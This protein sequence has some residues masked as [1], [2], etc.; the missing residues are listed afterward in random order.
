MSGLFVVGS[1]AA[2]RPNDLMQKETVLPCDIIIKMNTHNQSSSNSGAGAFFKH[3]LK[4]AFSTLT[5]ASVATLTVTFWINASIIMLLIFMVGIFA[6][7]SDDA[8][9]GQSD[10][11][12]TTTYGS[13]EAKHKILSIP[14]TGPIEG[15]QSGD[16]YGGIFAD[17][18][19]SYGYDLKRELIR[20]ANSKEYAAVILEI[21]SPGGT[22]YGSKAIADG[23]A[24][25]KEKTKRPVYASIQGMAASGGYWSAVSADKIIADSG[26]G[27]GSIGVIYGPFTYFDKP[28]AIDGGILGGGV[29]TQNGI[30]QTYI[31]AGEGK[32]A[33]NPFRRL[34]PKE[35]EVIQTSVNDAYGDF[36]DHVSRQRAI[37]SETIQASV[38]AHLYG[39]K[40]ALA[41]KLIDK[42]ASRE[43]AYQ[44]LAEVAGVSKNFRIVSSHELTGDFFSLLGSK[45]KLGPEQPVRSNPQNALACMG[46]VAVPLAYHGQPASACKNN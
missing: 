23:V 17:P 6:S 18:T 28:V 15:S 1:G 42:I 5:I 40:Q 14:V 38:G 16:S 29:I 20:A 13:E 44:E 39:E 32:D 41:N 3:Q 4:L 12:Y 34:T 24:Y 7:S 36:V 11:L 30:E 27:I 19:V 21:D 9:N 25:Y 8:A 43:E 37:S 10:Y 2:E 45:L 35:Q 31:T 33:G 22:I 26:T 46:E